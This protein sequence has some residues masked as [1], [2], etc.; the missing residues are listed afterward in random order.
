MHWTL[1]TNSENALDLLN[2]L[3]FYMIFTNCPKFITNRLK[4]TNYENHVEFSVFHNSKA[5]SE[6]V[7]SNFP[8]GLIS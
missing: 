5:F 2:S 8:V 3:E 6:L 4:M 1:K 7:S